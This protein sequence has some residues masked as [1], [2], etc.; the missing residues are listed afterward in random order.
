MSRMEQTVLGVQGEKD[1]STWKLK[2]RQ[3][4]D[5]KRR[6]ERKGGTG[7][8]GR[9]RDLGDTREGT[10]PIQSALDKGIFL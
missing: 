10:T 7:G 2:G 1:D 4:L 8:D 6:R 5:E 9:T 3:W